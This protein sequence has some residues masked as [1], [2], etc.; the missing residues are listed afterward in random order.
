MPRPRALFEEN[1]RDW[2]TSSGHTERAVQ[3]RMFSSHRG[4]GLTLLFGFGDS[5]LHK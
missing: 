1:F 2:R 3:L 4:L 5:L